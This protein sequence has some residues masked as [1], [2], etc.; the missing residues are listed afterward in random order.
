MA[1][2]LNRMPIYAFVFMLFTMANVGLPG[3]SGFVGEFLALI[4]TFKANVA[5]VA[6]ARHDRRHPPGLLTR[7]GST[8]RWLFGTL[9]QAGARRHP[10]H[11]LAGGSDSL[12]RW[13]CSTI[14]F[15]VAPKPVLDMSSASVAA[16]ASRATIRRSP[17]PR[18]RRRAAAAKAAG[19]GAMNEMLTARDLLPL[20][21]ELAARRPARLLMLMVGA[22][23]GE[24]SANV[25]NGWS[26]VILVVVAGFLL[27]LP[28]GKKTFCSAAVSWSIDYA[29]FLKF[30]TL[31]GSARALVLSLDVLITP[32]RS[33]RNSNNRSCSCCPRS[34][35]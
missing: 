7:S 29:R 31:I 25:V 20:L 24:R 17:A 33:S 15:G 8:A 10:R 30:L 22:F 13:S 4:G 12:P 2:S 28:A 19:S 16:T 1:G 6:G 26:I 9:P 21:P 27:S 35:C 3:T 32:P 18:P 11:R 5:A 34:A 23:S 14:L